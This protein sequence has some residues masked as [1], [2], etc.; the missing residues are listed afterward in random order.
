MALLDEARAICGEAH[1]R[2]GTPEDA[3]DG[4]RPAVV[5]EPGR[6]GEASALLAVATRGGWR[7]VVRGGGTKLA[8]GRPPDG[9]DLVLSTAR[10]DHLLEHAAGDLVARAQAGMPLARLQE[11]LAPAGQQLALDPPERGATLGGVVATGTAGPRRHRYGT[12]RDLLIGITVV[13]ADGTVARAGGKVVKNVAGYDLC[14]L[15]TGS[16]GTLGLIAEVTF[17]L[18]PL[19]RTRAA[20]LLEVPTPQHATDATLALART[21][22]VP[23]AVELAWPAGAAGGELLALF[24][25]VPPGV[26]AQVEQATA[27]LGAHGQARALDGAEAGEWL[28]RQAAPPGGGAVAVKAATLPSRLGGALEALWRAAEA[29]GLAVGAAAHAGVG[30]LH[31]TLRGGDPAAAARAVAAARKHLEAEGGNLVVTAAPVEVKR[32][33]DAWGGGGDA[34]GLMRRVKERF[35]PAGTLSPGRFLGGI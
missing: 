16:F 20:A 30:V 12:P 18:H 22:L 28:A 25:G 33:V 27:L 13:L 15:F 19:P 6:V 32:Q 23:S 3:V 29:E 17:R 9:L 11:A 34:L 10:M 31:A 4:V 5:A 21:T 7:V 8:W 1:A 35:D 26:A 24:E 2:P 14:K